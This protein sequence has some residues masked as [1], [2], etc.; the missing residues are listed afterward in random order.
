MVHGWHGG[1][2][3]RT[4]HVRS[5]S[6]VAVLFEVPGLLGSTWFHCVRSSASGASTSFHT[7]IAHAQ[8]HFSRSNKEVNETATRK[9]SLDPAI[10]CSK[11][12]NLQSRANVRRQTTAWPRHPRQRFE[13]QTTLRR[14]PS[15]Q[16]FVAQ[17]MDQHGH[18]STS[19]RSIFAIK[20]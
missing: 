9:T 16:G 8:C 2:Y 6:T 18:Y 10:L 3:M 1:S 7:L 11:R 5:L 12:K 4:I 13:C 20:T 14:I 17:I 19:G 15:F